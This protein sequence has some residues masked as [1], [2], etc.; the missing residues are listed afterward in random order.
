MSF[1]YTQH[2]MQRMA[3][4]QLRREW[5]ERVL[6]RPSRIE[7]DAIDQ[8]LEHRLAAVPQLANRVLRVIVS[9]DE[10]RRVVTVHL[11]R[12]MKGRL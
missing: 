7:P 8:A 1:V 3:K 10:P 9:K 6:A 2:A 5:V 4:R 12:G 11:D